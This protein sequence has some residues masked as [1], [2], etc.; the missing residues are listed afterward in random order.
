MIVFNGE[1]DATVDSKGRFLVPGGLRKQLR[2]GDSRLMLNRGFEGCLNM[3]PLENW[4]RI[5]A[6]IMDKNDYEPKVR[7]FKRKFL[8]GATIVEI[9]NAGRLLLPPSLRQHAGLEKDITLTSVGDRVE[10][11]DSGKYKQIFE[12]FSAQDFSNLAKEVM[13]GKDDKLNS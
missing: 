6:E 8:A 5:V 13:A 11:W 9:D 2:E 3:Y 1:Y 12:D 10:I 4:E 7:E